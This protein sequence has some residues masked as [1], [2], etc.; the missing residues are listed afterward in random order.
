MLM[1]MEKRNVIVT[2]GNSGIGRE[3]AK[4]FIEMGSEVAI[5]GR[6]RGTLAATAKELGKHCSWH[7]A[8]ISN[9]NQV[10]SV[11]DQ[12]LSRFEPIHVLVNSAGTGRTIT[13]EVPI[14]EAETLWDEVID[15]NLKGSFLMAT[16][17]TSHMMQPGGRIINVSSIGAYTGGSNPGG[18]AYASAKAGVIGLT[19]A[20][21][22]ELSPKGITANAVA[23]GFISQT[24]FFGPDGLPESAVQTIVS[25]I[26]V[27]RPGSPEDVAAA[28]RYLAA[29]EAS[30]VTGEVLH[31]NGGWLFAP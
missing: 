18:L 9:Q 31:V 22:R 14:E 17:C 12:I 21:A 8:D 20:L 7:Q 25:Q 13:T 4:C 23:P 26:P 10:Q 29:P 27:G 11:I 24:A 1:T 6:N 16:G 3:I 28:V 2:G 19:R 5:V 15:V 30:Y